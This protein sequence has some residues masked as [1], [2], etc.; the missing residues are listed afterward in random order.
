M[1]Q[2]NLLQQKVKNFTSKLYRNDKHHN[3]CLP[4]FQYPTSLSPCC[5][6][7]TWAWRSCSPSLLGVVYNSNWPLPFQCLANQII[8]P[9]PVVD[10]SSLRFQFTFNLVFNYYES[11]MNDLCFNLYSSTA[12]NIFRGGSLSGN[13]PVIYSF[14]TSLRHVLAN[15]L[16]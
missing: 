16:L 4:Y 5:G 15:L 9:H 7:L 8:P 14:T 12:M 2:G 11:K 3:R 10:Y 6:S 13:R 1:D